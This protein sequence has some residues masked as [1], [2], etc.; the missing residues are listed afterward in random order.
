MEIDDLLEQWEPGAAVALFDA[1][2]PSPTVR[3]WGPTDR[4]VPLASVTKPL[5]ALGCWIAAEE[6]V[7]DWADPAGP[8]GATVRHLLAHA[9]G[10]PMEGDEPIAAPGARRIYSNTGF[11]RLAAE[12]ERRSGIGWQQY[13]TEA[14]L[15][16]L[17][18]ASTRFGDSAAKDAESHVEDLLRFVGELAAPT[19]LH[20]STL[21]TAVEVH[22]PELDGVVPGFGQQRP[23]PWGLGVEIKGAKHPHWT[24]TGASARTFGHFGAAGTFLWFDPDRRVGA[25]GLGARAFGPWAADLWPLLG[26]ALLRLGSG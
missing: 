15:Q 21:A 23:C 19:L 13:V 1:S 17:G 8:E 12:L 18:M 9:S 22:F 25:I 14:V 2:D 16:P 6:G 10:L 7:W 5:V 24:P 11:D 3:R 4:V 26:D 20:P